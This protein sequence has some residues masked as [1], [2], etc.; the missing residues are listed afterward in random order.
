MFTNL[1]NAIV[2]IFAATGAVLLLMIFLQRLI[3]P[4]KGSYSLYVHLKEDDF[5]NEAVI[6]YAVQRIRFFGEENCTKVFVCCDG[7][8][9]QT[10]ERLQNAFSMYDF[11]R[12]TGL[13]DET[14]PK[15]DISCK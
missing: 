15:N 9:A 10:V 6:G 4:D 1:M 13:D 8:N 2:I 5:Q 3:R 7:V 11:V 14:E 12:F